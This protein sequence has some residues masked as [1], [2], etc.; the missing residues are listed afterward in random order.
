MCRRSPTQFRQRGQPTR[1]SDVRVRSVDSKGR[2]S[3]LSAGT[4]LIGGTGNGTAQHALGRGL[5]AHLEPSLAARTAAPARLSPVG[6]HHFR[7][8]RP[9]RRYRNPGVG[10]RRR[11]HD[12]LGPGPRSGVGEN[13]RPGAVAP[14]PMPMSRLVQRQPAQAL[15]SFAVAGVALIT[16]M[17]ALGNFALWLYAQNTVV[18]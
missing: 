7:G 10:R 2:L 4:P 16:I 13:R 12:R 5:A 9:D 18:A 11:L 3:R 14:A 17:L 8:G 1:G 6:E 15:A